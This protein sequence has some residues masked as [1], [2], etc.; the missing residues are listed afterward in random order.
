MF[1]S[2]STTQGPLHQQKQESLTYGGFLTVTSGSAC[3]AGSDCHSG[4]PRL[5]T[6]CHHTLAPCAQYMAHICAPACGWRCPH[7]PLGFYAFSHLLVR[8]P[9][10]GGSLGIGHGV[11]GGMSRAP[12]RQRSSLVTRVGA[13][14]APKSAARHVPVAMGC[15]LTFEGMRACKGTQESASRRETRHDAGGLFACGPVRRTWR[16]GKTRP[17]LF[18]AHMRPM[19]PVAP[20]SA[21]HVGPQRRLGNWVNAYSRDRG[22]WLVDAATYRDIWLECE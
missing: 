5:A 12:P 13:R 14:A 8:V 16:S 19:Q 2:E 11:G 3:W 15:C 20:Q 21:Q 6:S 9:R 4:A 7:V 22:V 10:S 1:C 17:P 18:L